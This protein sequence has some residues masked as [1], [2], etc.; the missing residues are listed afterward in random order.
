MDRV[1]LPFQAETER[2]FDDF[3]A[4][5]PVTS[6]EATIAAY[7]AAMPD[8]GV[9]LLSRALS[10]RDAENSGASQISPEEANE[11]YPNMRTPFRDSVNPYVAQMLADREEEQA[12]VQEKLSRGPTDIW[13]K[14]KQFGA[15][16]LAHAMDPLETLVG[17]GVG[18]AL[19][20]AASFGAFGKT[21]AVAA[22]MVATG[23]R[24]ST[25]ARLGVNV[26]EAVGGAA[27]ENLAQEAVIANIETKEGFDSGRT[28]GDIL[29]DYTVSTFAAGVIGVGLKEAIHFAGTKRM[30]RSTSPE[31]DRV[32]AAN[33]VQSVETDIVPNTRPMLE[34]LAQETSVKLEGVPEAYA[35]RAVTP[36]GVKTAKFFAVTKDA[37]PD[38]KAGQKVDLGDDYGFGTH[39]SDH[40]GVANAAATRAMAESPGVVHEMQVVGDLSPL[41]LV[42]PVRDAELSATLSE[43]LGQVMDNADEVLALEPLRNVLGYI[44]NAT[45]EGMLDPQ[46]MDFIESSIRER[47]Y[48]ALIDDGTRRL[49]FDHAEA[50]NHIILLDDSLISQKAAFTPDSKMVGAPDPQK[51]KAVSDY[52]ADPRNKFF[53]DMDSHEKAMQEINDFRVSAKE[54][55]AQVSK[56]LDS[57]L[58]ELDSL[59]KQ[60]FYTEPEAKAMRESIVVAR[61]MAEDEHTLLKAFKACA[62][63]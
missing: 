51:I 8:T 12:R 3:E 5:S 23:G 4:S 26:G 15:G 16:L 38:F 24:V 2:S 44:R 53:M 47:G 37:V 35:F 61:Q 9:G 46:T 59:E 17:M 54:D 28:T 13:T 63:A 60:G 40:P 58:E 19:G 25:A 21:A 20:R 34:A 62:G 6:S 41:P 49:G 22:D 7:E 30:L 55:L 48:N 50:H 31:A 39:I 18:G 52:Q 56:T 11:R 1:A 27:V 32:L 57:T 42:S 36:E 14:T 45:D 10:I 33:I 43:I 29:T